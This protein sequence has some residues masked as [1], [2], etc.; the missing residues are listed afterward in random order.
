M[1]VV[2]FCIAAMPYSSMKTALNHRGE[3]FLQYFGIGRRDLKP[4]Q[5]CDCT[6][7]RRDET[8]SRAGDLPVMVGKSESN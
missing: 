3:E 5:G 1:H 4:P 6:T 7:Q 2:G 8:P